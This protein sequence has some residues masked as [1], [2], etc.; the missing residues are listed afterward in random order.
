ML[1]KLPYGVP[2]ERLLTYSRLWQFETWLRTM[3]YTEL[4]ARYGDSWRTH[5]K[6][7]SR[8]AYE[9]DKRLSYMPTRES[10]TTSYM[11]LS[12]LIES[13]S[14]NWEL[15][16]P[17]LPPKDI[18]D[19]KIIEYSQIRHRVAHFRLGH[20]DDLNRVEQLLRDVDNGFWHFCTSYNSDVPILPQSKDAVLREFLHLDPFPWTEIQPRHWSRVGVADPNMTVSATVEV[21]RRPWLNSSQPTK[22]AGEY[23]YFYDIMLAARDH[24]RF[25]YSQFLVNT[26]STHSSICHICLDIFQATLRLTIPTVLG[27]T[28]I[29]EIIKMLISEARNALRPNAAS[30]NA[31]QQ[32]IFVE[33]LVEQWP[34][35]V[36]GPSS[37]LTFLGPGMPCSF[38][39]LEE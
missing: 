30:G 39:G 28:S 36:L 12:S 6:A 20:R 4:F 17:Y 19:V 23:G 18:W 38:F 24:R 32:K 13:I 29:V 27:K 14:S 15:F 33:S 22:V 7:H 1:D 11:Q 37:P 9:K 31:D 8:N 2:P 35:Y 26:K 21:L 34:E 10:L 25:D 3:A 16:K 5:L